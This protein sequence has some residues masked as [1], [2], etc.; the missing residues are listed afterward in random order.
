MVSPFKQKKTTKFIVIKVFTW[1]ATFWRDCVL[2]DVTSHKPSFAVA[3]GFT[4]PLA[5][6]HTLYKLC[7]ALTQREQ[8]R[9]KNFWRVSSLQ[10]LISADM[11]CVIISNEQRISRATFIFSLC[12]HTV[13][14]VLC[15]CVCVLYVCVCGQ[16]SDECDICALPP[17]CFLRMR[18]GADRCGHG[19]MPPPT[20]F[21][22]SFGW[23]R[24]I[25]AITWAHS[26]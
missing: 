18:W 7:Q 17:E 2:S 3:T 16:I 19:S 13:Q 22:F 8:M 9:E 24:K 15:V 20:H 14:L 11:S 26:R 21:S 5:A 6:L 25:T 4:F 10:S 12:S 1:S 23:M